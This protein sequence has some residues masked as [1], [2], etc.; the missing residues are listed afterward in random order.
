MRGKGVGAEKKLVSNEFYLLLVLYLVLT[1]TTL[2]GPVLAR[3]GKGQVN[4]GASQEQGRR[5]LHSTR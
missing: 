5:P 4:V 3:W 1:T 2:R